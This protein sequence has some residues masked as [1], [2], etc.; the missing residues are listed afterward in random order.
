MSKS[1][2]REIVVDGV[3]Y[4][5][6]LD[7][8]TIN[9]F[10]ETHIR[11]HKSGTTGGILYVDPYNWHFEVRPKFVTQAIK[12]ALSSDWEPVSGKKGMYVSYLDEKYCVLPNGIKFGY[13]LKNQEKNITD[14]NT[15][16]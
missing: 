11:I 1:V 2:K 16:D 5:W 6:V 13:Q 10:N 15:L 4:Y 14:K 3:Q 8:N 7:G 12:F 9:G